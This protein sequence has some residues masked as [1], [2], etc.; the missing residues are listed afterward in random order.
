MQRKICIKQ[1]IVQK[2]DIPED[3]LKIA[4]VVV[5]FVFFEGFSM[6]Y[7]LEPMAKEVVIGSDNVFRSGCRNVSHHYQQHSFSGLP[8]LGRSLDYTIKY[9]F[10]V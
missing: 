5:G 3:V 4:C 2:N 6:T 9:Y 8:S 10:W 7:F 1:Y